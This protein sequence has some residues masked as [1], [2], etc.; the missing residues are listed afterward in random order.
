MV[1]RLHRLKDLALLQNATSHYTV[2]ITPLIVPFTVTQGRS[3]VRSLKKLKRK[4][5]STKHLADCYRAVSMLSVM[6]EQ[7]T[8]KSGYTRGGK[9]FEVSVMRS[10][11]IGLS[12]NLHHPLFS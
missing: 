4:D 2:S 8:M 6:N 9:Y 3:F 10:N 1:Q 7:L 12:L 11:S 5:P